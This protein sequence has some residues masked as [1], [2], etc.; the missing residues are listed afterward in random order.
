MGIAPARSLA[1]EVLR[2]VET[3]GYAADLLASRAAGLDQRD[4]GLASEIVLGTLRRQNQLDFLLEHFSGRPAGRLDPEVRIALRMGLYQ[5]RYLDRIPA[6]AA[7]SES[8][9]LVKRAGKHSAG[10]LVNAVLRKVHRQPVSFPDLA[11]ELGHPAWLL[12][13]WV[14]QFGPEQARRIALANL[15]A[16]ETYVRIPVGYDS[17]LAEATRRESYPTAGL[18]PTEVPGCFRVLEGNPAGWRIQDI[19][20]QAIVPLLEL[21]PGQWFL[22][23]CAAPGNKT[24]Q[25][26]E[27]KVRAVACDVHPRRLAALKTLGCD[28]VVA[29]GT[30]TLPFARRFDRI[31]VDAP[32][33]G[34]GTL[35]RNPEIKWRLRPSDLVDLHAR[36]VALLGNALER[37]A[38]GGRLVYSTCSLEAEEN[39]EVVRE[40]LD[41]T[42]IPA[43]VA[44]WWRRLPGR[45]R[46]DGFFAAVITSEE[47]LN[48]SNRSFDSLG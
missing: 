6:H 2:L 1:F 44:P 23:V 38:P 27:S 28:L 4:A 42:A 3:G 14:R 35:A 46:G 18:E 26:L 43:A 24:A 7:V 39:E 29:D 34:T 17:S 40:V 19:S 31:L 9:E 20:S 10:G 21:A 8:V 11:T 22:D 5:L 41:S 37:L 33:S 36:Q 30:R 12:E 15:E 48:D 13:R 47:P 25:A 32:C 45:D 16:P